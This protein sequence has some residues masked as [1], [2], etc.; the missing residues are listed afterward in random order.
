[1]S[2]IYEF[3]TAL[4]LPPENVQDIEKKGDSS[5]LCCLLYDGYSACSAF[6]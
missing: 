4:N 5:A 1:M 6:N 2:A 3:K